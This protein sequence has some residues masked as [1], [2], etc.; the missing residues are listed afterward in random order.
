[1]SLSQA[2]AGD[3]AEVVDI[4][5]DAFLEDPIMKWVSL[6]PTYP[7]F[8]FGL[9]TPFCVEQG[10][11][12]TTEDASGAISWLPPRVALEPKTN[13]ASIWRGLRDFGPKSLVRA[14]SMLQKMSKHHPREPHYYLFSIGTRRSAQG[15]GVGSSLIRPG[16]EKCDAEGVPAY[17]ESSNIKNLPFYRKHGFEVVQELRLAS[18]GPTMW[19]MWRPPVG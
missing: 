12:F 18:D 16:L 9:A 8:A 4:L 3:V 14:V 7:A 15:R 6:S 5:A 11:T 10:H 19:L 13:P 1:M 17:L 2:G